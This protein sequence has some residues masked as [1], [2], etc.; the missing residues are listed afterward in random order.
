MN[1]EGSV[2][3][4]D[5]CGCGFPTLDHSVR[6]SSTLVLYFFLSL[7]K[8]LH[9]LVQPEHRKFIFHYKKDIKQ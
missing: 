3:V 9:L 7:T 5:Y 1:S 2:N 4:L 8:Y 6:G